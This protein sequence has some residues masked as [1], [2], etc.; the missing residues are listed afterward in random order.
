M[1]TGWDSFTI[2]TKINDF[3]NSQ[4]NDIS[5]ILLVNVTKINVNVAFKIMTNIHY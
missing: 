2:P 1:Y 5:E 4:H 3:D